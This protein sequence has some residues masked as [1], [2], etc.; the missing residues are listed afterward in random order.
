MYVEVSGAQESGYG[1]DS[2]LLSE[3]MASALIGALDT[4]IQF[5]YIRVEIV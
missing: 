4:R 1:D 2:T 5:V 3:E